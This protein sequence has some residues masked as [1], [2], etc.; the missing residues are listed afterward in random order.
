MR[1]L[2]AAVALG[3]LASVL[4]AG[5]GGAQQAGGGGGPILLGGSISATGNLST[6]ANYQLQGMQLAID[7][8]NQQGGVLGRQLKFVYYD[9]KSDAGTAVRL[10]DKLITQDKVNF[11]LGPY[12][13]GITQAMASVPNKYQVV[14]VDGG[15]S[16]PTIFQAPNQYNF[17][18][19]APSQTYIDQVLP[20]A[21]QHG[22]TKVALL[23]Y[24]SAYSLACG[25]ARRKQAKDL[26][27]DIVYDNTYS[28]P[29]PD[30]SPQ[31]LGIKNAAAQ[32]VL[33][34]TYYPDSVGIAQALN[35]IGYKPQI[36]AETIGPPEEGFLKTLGPVVN[37]IVTNTQ[38]WPT[39]HNPG[40]AEFVSA[41]KSKYGI[42]PD[43][44][45][46]AGYAAVQI[47]AE[48]I[49]RAGSLDQ[50]KVREAILKGNIPTVQGVWNCDQYGAPLGIKNY[51]AQYQQ[52]KLKLVYPEAVAEAPIQVPYTGS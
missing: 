24:N 13:S 36:F 32:V 52:E 40:N 33:G 43:Y 19:V 8:I 18:D 44:H 3:A 12:S 23:V 30:F 29:I 16:L 50:A 45:T 47:L 41:Y 22:L 51:L 10:Y 28:L 26:G 31:A 2:F 38:W 11:L 17:S 42:E 25:A 46:A 15:A 20:I 48:G 1:R 49:K 35:R 9:D 27:F 5:C 14:S 34:C 39:L 7:Q 21:K 6:D 37:G 4:L